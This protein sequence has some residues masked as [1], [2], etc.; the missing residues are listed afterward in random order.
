MRTVVAQ[1]WEESERGWGTSDDG[2]SLHANEA[3]RVAFVKA[4]WDEMP[5]YAPDIYSR[6]S[7]KP[8]LVDLDEEN[9]EADLDASENG[10]RTYRWTP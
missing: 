10:I 1:A 8:F 3:D 4:Y 9:L 7:G 5:D 6:P 2:Y